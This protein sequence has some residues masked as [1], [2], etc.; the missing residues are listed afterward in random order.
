M[1]QRRAR[2]AAGMDPNQAEVR[3]ESVVE[4]YVD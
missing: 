2:R 1:H 4:G 3:A